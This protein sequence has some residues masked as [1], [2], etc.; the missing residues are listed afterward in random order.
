MIELGYNPKA[1]IFGPG[2]NFGFYHTTFKAAVNGVMCWATWNRKMSPAFND[3]ANKLYPAGV[4]EEANDW[5]GHALYFGAME[6]WKQAV[7]KAG[8]LDNKKVQQ[9]M[10]TSHF[11]TVLGD[12]FFTDGLMAKESHP[13][14]VG[15]WQNEVVEIIGGNK[16]TASFIYPKPP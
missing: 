6:F 7:E 9:V 11:Q 15:Q 1:V 5:W 13:G 12:T 2:A 14:E 8:S 3:M 10:A 16:T 4:P